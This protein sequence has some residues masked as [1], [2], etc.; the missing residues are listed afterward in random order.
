MN[1]LGKLKVNIDLIKN[2]KGLMMDLVFKIHFLIWGW[3]LV[4]GFVTAINKKR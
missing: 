3:I 4:I 1:M 2:R